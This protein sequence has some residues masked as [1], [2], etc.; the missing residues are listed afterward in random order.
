MAKG[1]RYPGP[2]VFGLDIGTRSIVGTVGYMFN[3]KFHVVAIQSRL[4]ETRAMLDGQIHDIAAV[5]DSI[6][7]VKAEL[8]RKTGQP[9]TDVCIAAAGRVLR[10]V[11][12]HVEH[13]FE[14][15]TDVNAEHIYSLELLGAQKAYEEFLKNNTLNMRFYCVGYTVERYY[16]NKYQMNELLSHKGSEIGADVIATFLPDEVVDGLYKAVGMAGLNVA[17]MTLE[18]I[19]AMELAIP[20]SY[21]M[22]NLALVDVGAGTSDISITR[23]G[24]IIAYGMIPSAGDELT[25]AIARHFLTD[26]DEAEKIKFGVNSKSAIEFTDI[27]G[28]KQKTDAKEVQEI[29][30]PTA[31]V[32]A[33]EVSDQIKKLNGGKPVSAIFLV[34]GGGKVPIFTELLAEEMQIAPERVAVRGEEVLKDVDFRDDR[35]KKDSLLVTP[36]GIC[37]N[38]YNQVNNF[39]F[40]SFNG[41][42]IKLY[43]NDHLQIVDAA[44]A[45]GFSNADLFPKRGEEVKYTVNGKQRVARGTMGESAVVRLNGENAPINAR[46]KAGDIIEV[47][48]ST[49]GEPAKVTVES[50]PEYKQSIKINVNDKTVIMPKF[51]AV[52]GELQSGYYEI[53]DGDEVIM[54]DYYTVAQVLDFMD[55]RKEDDSEIYVNHE[56]AYSD[57][58][59]YENFNVE[60]DIKQEELVGDPEER[61]KKEARINEIKEVFRGMEEEA[62]GKSKDNSENEEDK[63]EK[64]EDKKEADEPSREKEDTDVKEEEDKKKEDE[65]E[66]KEEEP[67]KEEETDKEEKEGDEDGQKKDGSD[68]EEE[69]KNPAGDLSHNGED[70][71]DMRK[72]M[73]DGTVEL[74]VRVNG[75]EVVLSGK[76]EYIYVDVFDRIDFDL[77]K[78]KGK[79]VITKLNGI[80]TASYAEKL[81]QGDI[82]E[83][84]WQG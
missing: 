52:N 84:Y 14:E 17:N 51:A 74:T 19:A 3:K 1:E 23:D 8:Q 55:I 60:I 32:I 68:E 71:E 34:G 27:M 81:R 33:R 16:L 79:T 62:E 20:K 61:A 18:P 22:L 46:I 58:P 73:P 11:T 75:D 36:I 56:E 5:A 37:L 41:N 10:T 70:W 59:V 2:L 15:D 21:R 49:A 65:E 50:L 43:D 53:Q 69:I 78:P 82:L 42:Q 76:K 4:H 38:F 12:V 72:K 30:R 31:S 40:V 47:E 80:R 29:L 57:M 25:E 64:K 13:K 28:I 63:E 39:I 45:S 6:M 26:F 9:L 83:I 7:D 67:E 24:A 54:R 48:A 35:V 66:I 77:S 44:M